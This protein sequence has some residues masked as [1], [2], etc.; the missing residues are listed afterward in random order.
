[1]GLTSVLGTAMSGLRATQDALTIVSSNV[2]NAQTP[3][4]IRRRPVLLED[5]SDGN[6]TGVRTENAQ[7][8]LD[9]LLQRELRTETAGAAYTSANASY[10]SSL[11]RIYGKP[12]DTTALDATF[13]AFTQSLQALGNDPSNSTVR[14]SVLNAAGTLAGR[15]RSASDGVQELRSNAESQIATDVSRAN[16]LLKGIAGLNQQVLGQTSPD[17]GI[18]DARDSQIDELSKLVD[19]KVGDGSNGTVTISTQNGARL[20]DGS[21]PV[22]L[23]F[24]QR[25]AL[26][27]QSL[28]DTDP[29]KRG[30]GTITAV[31]SSGYS[32]DLIANGG[33]RAGEIAALVDMRD[34]VLVDA[35]GQLDELA[36]QLS[37]ALSDRTQAG[38][39]ASSGAATG[40]DVDLTG[41][42]KG[43]AITLDY[44]EGGV[45]KRATFV[46]VDDPSQLPLSDAFT[47]D[48]GDK[49]FGINFSGG[50]ASVASQVQ[51]ALGSGLAVSASGSSLRILDDGATGSTDVTGLAARITT[52]TLASGNPEI[53]LFVDSNG[54]KAFTNGVDGGAQKLGYASRIVINPAA[55]GASLV[56][57]ASTTPGSDATRPNLM[58][59]RLTSATRTFDPVGGVGSAGAP[60]TNTVG[61]YLEAVVSSQGANAAS[62]SRLD[63]GQQVVLTS[64]QSRFAS[65]S[66]VNVDEEMANLVQL[67]NAYAANARV[68]SAAKDMMDLLLRM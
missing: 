28:Y 11:E 47:P 59:D 58:L 7:R 44:V 21:G 18:L 52:T 37:S 38:A 64:I 54:N 1:M 2:A 42:Q 9:S 63:E 51:A 56:A 50:M 30:V 53:P 24:D 4:Y 25:G 48:P 43:N 16:E 17:A 57:Y 32:I 19:I 41:L 55:T 15:I 29:T 65:T 12:G 26:G 61:S 5:V 46:R 3:G 40:F 10:A 6:V 22:K 31:D 67:Q 35:Q 45:T 8:I 49:V 33:I 13:N 60:F 68:M 36:G 23:V 34:K 39:A 20:L 27:P 62:A 66:G 14:A